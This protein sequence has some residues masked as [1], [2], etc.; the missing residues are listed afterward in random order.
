VFN[1]EWKEALA[2]AKV[3]YRIPYTCRHTRAS[4]LLTAGIDSAYAAKQMGHTLEMFH[5]TYAEGIDEMRG[6]A[7]REKIRA[8]GHEKPPLSQLDRNWTGENFEEKKRA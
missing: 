2:R 8:L 7:Q 1:G 5:R 6:A 4:E 3:R